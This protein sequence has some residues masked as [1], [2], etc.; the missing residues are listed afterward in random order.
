[1]DAG[2]GFV[3]V[4]GGRVW[5]EIV[6]SG[7]GIPMLV[8]HGGPGFTHEYCRSLEALA[9]ERP[10]V[11]YDQ[12]GCGRSERPDDLSLWTVDR[13]VEELGQL[14]RGLG[15]ERL[16]LFGQSWGTMLAAEYMLHAGTDGI[17]GAVFASPCISIPRWVE[18]AERLKAALPG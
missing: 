1:M 5:Y 4:E 6:G 13:H 15:L 14:R 10:V 16:H 2:E 9:D 7:R 12:L 3:E 18:D 8:L 17:A 11:F